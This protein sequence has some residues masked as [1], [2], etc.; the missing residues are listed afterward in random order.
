MTKPSLDDL[1]I[2]E[3]L[4]VGDNV[5]IIKDEE[6]AA[7]PGGIVIPSAHRGYKRRG[8]VLAVGGGH[9]VKG[10]RV[11]PMP[12]KP[13]DYLFADRRFQRPD[14]TEDEIFHNPTILLIRGDD[15]CVFIKHQDCTG[16]Y[17]LPEKLVPLVKKLNPDFD[18]KDR[19]N[20][21]GG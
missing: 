17:R 12:Y 14:E 7:S 11:V 3:L 5:F 10:G 8:W 20:D 4:P 19:R 16:K 6:D 15:P 13:G 9:R 21:T 1:G 2:K 18:E